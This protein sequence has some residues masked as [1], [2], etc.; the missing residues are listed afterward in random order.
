MSRPV[1]TLMALALEPIRV[2][3]RMLL[4][5]GMAPVTAKLLD[6][7]MRHAAVPAMA[8]VVE[9]MGVDADWVL[10][11]H[12]HR[13]GPIGHEHWPAPSDH[14]P[15]LLNTG[16]WLYEPLLVDRTTPPHPYW[17]GGAVVLEEGRP[18]RTVGLLDDVSADQLYPQVIS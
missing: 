16:A 9:R 3:P 18:P 17:P 10:F 6:L 15:R 5:A 1:G 13:L 7:Q 2:L 8:R 14:G 4:D 12:V 11:G